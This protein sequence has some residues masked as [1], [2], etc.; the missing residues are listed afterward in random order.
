M[1]FEVPFFVMSTIGTILLQ[2]YYD[3]RD[4]AV[5]R[6]NLGVSISTS[7]A[8]KGILFTLKMVGFFGGR[9][10][11]LDRVVCQREGTR[12]RERTNIPVSH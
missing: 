4:S 1:H 2:F 12:S 5:V 10:E 8:I 6:V 11:D 9:P 7:A 3:W